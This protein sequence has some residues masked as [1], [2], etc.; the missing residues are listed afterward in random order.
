MNNKNDLMNPGD[1][2]LQKH[3]NGLK[4]YIKRF[5]HFINEIQRT[6]QTRYYYK[7]LDIIYM[8]IGTYIAL[9]NNDSRYIN[10]IQRG[11]DYVD[12]KNGDAQ[13]YLD[14]MATHEGKM[15][16]YNYF[17]ELQHIEDEKVYISQ[18]INKI[19]ELFKIEI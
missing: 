19:N 13:N 2:I 18:L 3:E 4:R 8:I 5:K 7:G 1:N 14:S 9:K 17:N 10:Y 12:Y 6:R 15:F 16:L 11:Q